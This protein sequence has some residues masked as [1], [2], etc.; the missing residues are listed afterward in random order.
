MKNVKEIKVKTSVEDI[1][2][3]MMAVVRNN[4]GYVAYM[5]EVIVNF[6]K[7]NMHLLDFTTVSVMLSDV[8]DYINSVTKPEN[9]LY[10]QVWYDFQLWLFQEQALIERQF[11][12]QKG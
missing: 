9:E 2:L 1:R 4:L 3:I 7:A 6:I 5:P 8:T 11:L 12:M 10:F